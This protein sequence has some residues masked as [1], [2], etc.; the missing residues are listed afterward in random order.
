MSTTLN[1]SAAK[2]ENFRRVAGKRL[3]TA[4]DAIDRLRPTANRG[5]YEYSEEQIAKVVGSLRAAV[6][7]LEQ[8]YLTSGARE[9]RR[10]EL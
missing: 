2:R 1:R 5:N 6:D 4:L 9:R 3:N 8:A 10:V 7:E